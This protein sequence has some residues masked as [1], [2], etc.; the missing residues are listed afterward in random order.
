MK[1]IQIAS[2]GNVNVL[3]LQEINR[4][5]PKAG[6]ALLRM[7]AAGVNYIDI[8]QREGRYL[9][10]LPYVPGLEGSGVVEAVGPGVTEVK[11][12]DRVAYTMS[13]GSYAEFNVVPAASLIP[14]PKEMSFEEG[15]AFP[16]QGMTA[17]Y[18]VHEFYRIKAGDTV[19]IHAAAGGVGLLLVQWV[20]HLGA[21]V[22]GTVST[23]EKAKIAMQA[24]A[25][26]TILYTQQDFV[27]EVKKLTQ[28]Q[29][30]DYIIDGVGQSTFT[31]DLDA[32]RV[33]GHIC[34]FGSSSG[35]ANPLEPN[36][37]Q[38]KSITLS[39]GALWNYLRTREELLQ[40][41]NDVLAAIREG[42]L[43]LKIDHVLPLEQAAEAQTLLEG[44]K[45]VGKVVLKIGG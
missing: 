19:L 4:P 6:E 20:K 9:V 27:T 31:K 21:K 1:A 45:T 18:L 24:G 30:V 42:W 15:A 8:Y 37:L 28:D 36:S 35:T 7:K 38:A 2:P 10:E 39:G 26:H 33:R 32:I 13:A 11:P 44:R 29:G 12:G 14:L 22:I 34:L 5:E 16:L 3:Q 40:R 41:S 23:P 17:H 43:K 25:D